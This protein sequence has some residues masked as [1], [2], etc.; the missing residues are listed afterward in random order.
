MTFHAP[1][2]PTHNSRQEFILPWVT[3]YPISPP[4]SKL[5]AWGSTIP[6][7]QI[8]GGLLEPAGREGI[9]D[10]HQDL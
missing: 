3:P 1:S 10:Y 6:D 9:S 4:V 7:P 2:L 5:A 8:F